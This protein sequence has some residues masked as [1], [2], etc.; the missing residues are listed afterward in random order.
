MNRRISSRAVS[1][2]STFLL[3]AA[4]GTAACDND[5]YVDEGFYCADENGVI[6][7]ED[8]CDDDGG[9]SGGGG[10]GFFIW[11]SS[12]YRSGY[13]VGSRLPAG[14]SRFAYNDAASRSRFGL[15]SSGKISNGTVKTSVV[16]KGG[17]GSSSGG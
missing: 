6:V 10:G 12:S 11:H 7:D 1:L 17:S 9:R 4:G 16:G 5:E 8:Y 14:G 3:L 2:T 15:P 13:P